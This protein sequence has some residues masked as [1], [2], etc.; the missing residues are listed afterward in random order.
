MKYYFYEGKNI[1]D[2]GKY[3]ACFEAGIIKRE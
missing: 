3:D 1:N 2:Y